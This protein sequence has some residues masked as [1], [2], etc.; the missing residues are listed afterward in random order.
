[1]GNVTLEGKKHQSGLA[2]SRAS[3]VDLCHQ[4]SSFETLVVVSCSVILVQ[5]TQTERLTF[6]DKALNLIRQPWLTRFNKTHNLG[7]HIRDF[8]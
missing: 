7:P 4:V 2:D 5:Y 6:G 8:H 3:R 1:M